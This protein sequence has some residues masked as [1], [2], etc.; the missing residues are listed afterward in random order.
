MFQAMPHHA[1][2][3]RDDVFKAGRLGM[4]LT[5]QAIRVLDR[6]AL[7]WFARVTHVEF[8]AGALKE[9]VTVR[10]LRPVVKRQFAPAVR[11]QPLQSPF[12]LFP[13]VVLLLRVDLH[14]DRAP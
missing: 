4:N 7:M 6:A 3:L 12:D 2:V 10:G 14:Q 1:H 5:D 13:D 9:S 8:D 11:A